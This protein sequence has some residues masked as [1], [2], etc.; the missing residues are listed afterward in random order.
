MVLHAPVHYDDHELLVVQLRGSERWYVSTKP[1]ELNNTWKSIP[2]GAP[3][4]GPHEAFDMQPGDLVYL[5]RGRFHSVDSDSGSLHVS[6][7]FTPVPGTM[8]AL[9]LDTE[10]LQ[11][12]MAFCHLTASPQ[13]IDARRH[14]RSRVRQCS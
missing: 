4:L 2:A 11:N 5:S 13:L 14:H 1:S 3:D 6:V 10:L 12:E 9:S 8:P 7:G